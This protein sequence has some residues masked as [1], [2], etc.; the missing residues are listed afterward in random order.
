MKNAGRRK[1]YPMFLAAICMVAGFLSPINVKAAET[2]PDPPGINARTGILIEASTGS[3]LYEKDA[4]KEMYPASTTKLLT[5]LLAIENSDMTDEITI[6]EQAVYSIGSDAS[7]I[8]MVPGEIIS[9][10]DAIYAVLLPS[11]NEVSYAVAEYIGKGDVDVFVDMMNARAEELGCVSS[12]FSN[13]HGLHDSDHYTCA[14]D[15]ALI[16]KKCIEYPEFVRISNNSYHTIPET[17]KKEARNVAQTHKILRKRI[18]CEGVFAGK[19]GFTDEAGRCLVTAAE[20]NGMTLICVVLGAPT[21]DDSYN[22]TIRLLDYGFASFEKVRA[23]AGKEGINAFPYLFDDSEAF[24]IPVSGRL[25]ITESTLV[26]PKGASIADVTL[27]S[28]LWQLS[29]LK[30]GENLIGESLFYY[31]GRLV[32]RADI[33]Y[34]SEDDMIIDLAEVYLREYG[35]T[36]EFE[37]KTYL[38]YAGLYE[39]EEVKKPDARPALIGYGIGTLVSLVLTIFLIRIYLI[40]RR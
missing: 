1:K 23:T 25:S 35:D 18:E 39:E 10:E 13:P 11:A 36:D 17:N 24:P 27:D 16:M 37:E 19:T 12:H 2:W 6:S 20:R 8:A 14:Y 3:I 32:G 22:D 26:L 9:M 30:K 28:K 21:E 29:E 5:A 7:N 40:T 4:Q 38:I 31:G 15:I 34:D 33:M